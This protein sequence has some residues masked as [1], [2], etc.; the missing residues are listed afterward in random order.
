MTLHPKTLVVMLCEAVL[1]PQLIADCQRLGAHG[2]TIADA[3]GGGTR[4]VRA[5]T[6]D[7]DRSIR[8]EVICDEAT[9]AAIVEHVHRQYFAHYAMTLYTAD[10]GVLRPQKF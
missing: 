9:A 8:M 6:W 4:G 1:E 7:A 2:Y 3:R 5:A 10:I